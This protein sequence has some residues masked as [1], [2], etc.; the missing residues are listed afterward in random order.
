MIVRRDK[1]VSIEH[2]GQSLDEVASSEG[3][4]FVLIL[5]CDANDYSPEAIDPILKRQTVPLI[6]GVFPA[7]LSGS[8]RWEEGFVIVGFDQAA[9]V[10]TVTGL[11]D[12]DADFEKT[13]ESIDVDLAKAKTLMV[14]VD[15]LSSRINALVEELF[16]VF[17]LEANYIGGG[18]GSLSF[19]KKPCVFTN[20]G[21]KADC[22]VIAFAELEA[23]IGVSHGWRE[24]AGPFEVT[25]ADRN[26]VVS[27]DW[28][29]AQEVYQETVRSQAGASF[30]G[31]EFFEV[32]K[33]YPF[34][35]SKLGSEKIVR[36]PI[37]LDE[38][39]SIVC[40]GEVPTNAFVHVL[41]GDPESLIGAAGE[42]LRRAEELFRGE[43]ESRGILLI[44]CISRLLF[45]GDRFRDELIAMSP[46]GDVPVFG[47]LTLGEIANNRKDYLEF[48]N[49]TAVVGVLQG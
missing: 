4:R 28:R 5:A 23:G 40:V 45:L 27:L 48:Y 18:A 38:D 39:G 12:L 22:A 32:S 15:G 47:A 49:K 2:F 26:K 46:D 10:R 20:D 11:S 16:A 29:P 37:S 8:D 14:Y 25:E 21:L 6:G 34:G 43:P 30:E 7:I 3:V 36:D 9:K 24:L 42:A 31:V 33:G 44:D 19:E 41:A 17:G 35:I 1:S 13:L